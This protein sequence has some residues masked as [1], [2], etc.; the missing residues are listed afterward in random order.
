MDQ[1]YPGYVGTVTND[2]STRPRCCNHFFLSWALAG[3]RA[4]GLPRPRESC[5]AARDEVRWARLRRTGFPQ[6]PYRTHWPLAAARDS[7]D[8]WLHHGWQGSGCYFKRLLRERQSR[9]EAPPVG[10]PAGHNI[11]RFAGPRQL[12]DIYDRV[13]PVMNHMATLPLPFDPENVAHAIAV[14]I[15]GLSGRGR[16]DLRSGWGA[17]HAR[18]PQGQTQSEIEAG[19]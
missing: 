13:A 12:D 18:S 16:G 6:I 11:T 14:V 4:S 3:R 1:Y 17:A 2:R 5:C 10:N 7:A 19:V 8:E 9:G 15:A